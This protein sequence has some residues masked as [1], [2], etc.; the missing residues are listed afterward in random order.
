MKLVLFFF[1]SMLWSFTS[2]AQVVAW[3][4][5][6]QNSRH[7]MALHIGVDFGTVYG[8]S[9]GYKF[10][11]KI[12][13]VVGTELST[14][15]GKTFMDDFKAKLNVQTIFY[16]VN[17]LGISIKPGMIFR[18]YA[19]E[20]AVLLNIGSELGTT[21]GYY[22]DKW[23]IAFEANYDHT[24][25]TLIE[26]RLLKEYYSEIQDGWYGSTGGS[27]KFG[28]QGSYWLKSTGIALK[29]GKIFGQNFSEDPTLPFY[30]DISVMKKW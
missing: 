12:P 26:H 9:Y 6:D 7:I 1:L 5:P 28:L 10:S 11:G 13:A 4:N 23:S 19:S 30:A 22:R 15:F 8:I 27:F 20:A 21:I 14:P 18:R 17:H 25:A 3:Y 24:H 16:P 2:V 29:A